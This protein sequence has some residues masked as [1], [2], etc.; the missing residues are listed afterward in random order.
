[1]LDEVASIDPTFMGTRDKKTAL[2]LGTRIEA[3]LASVKMRVMSAADDVAETTGARS[4]AHWLADET[5]DSPA[6]VRRDASLAAALEARWGQVAAALAT[7]DL[8][9]AQT[10]AIVDALG[11]LPK[12]LGDDLRVKAEAYLVEKAAELGPPE[13]RVLGGR[14][15]E[16]LAPE[17]A[18]EAEYRRL[19]ADERRAEA[20]TRLTLRHRGDGSTDLHA[21][22]PTHAAGL[23]RTYLN[24]FTAPRRRHHWSGDPAGVEEFAQLPLDRQRGDAFVALLENTPTT[25]LPRHGGTTTSVMVTLDHALLAETGVASTSTGDRITAGQARRLACQAGIIPVVLGGRSEILDVGRSRRLV[26]D[27]IRKAMNLRDRTCTTVGCSMPAAFCEAHHVVPWSRGGKTSLRDSKLLC[28]FHHHRAH[29][30]R[31]LT[32]HHPHGKTSFHPRT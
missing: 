9:L 7:G 16:H 22:I 29:D 18:E 19:L 11:A 31:W 28:S 20:A 15:L 17:I 12:D 25:S 2:T 14:V 6:T 13:L 10:R 30:P 26:T 21:R 4:T 5:R 1:M 24:A 32:T 8:N 27:P 3:R 23:L